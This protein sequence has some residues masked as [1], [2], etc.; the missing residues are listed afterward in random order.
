[1]GV[2]PC[3]RR[4]RENFLIILGGDFEQKGFWEKGTD[5]LKSAQDRVKKKGFK[6]FADARN[7]DS[8]DSIWIK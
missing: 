4:S 7:W 1:V 8:Y 2:R 3:F 6:L 5:K